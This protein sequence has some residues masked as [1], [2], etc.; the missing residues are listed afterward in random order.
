MAQR[1][2]VSWST[3]VSLPPGNSN[4]RCLQTGSHIRNTYGIKV[5]PLS[6][7]PL[8]QSG[9]E[10]TGA[11]A[12]SWD[13]NRQEGNSAAL[14]CPLRPLL[15]HKLHVSTYCNSILKAA[16]RVFQK[17]WIGMFRGS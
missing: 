7:V 6:C 5:N 13:L 17:N 8:M 2:H 1:G 12:K 16:G 4:C 11:R 10:E 9:P 15:S 14:V 3:Y